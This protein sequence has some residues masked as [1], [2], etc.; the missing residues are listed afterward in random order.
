MSLEEHVQHVDY[1]T[2]RPDISPP[3][4]LSSSLLDDRCGGLVI[5]QVAKW[6]FLIKMSFKYTV[7]LQL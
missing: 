5:F 6:L 1:I 4:S 7:T 3:S 2:V